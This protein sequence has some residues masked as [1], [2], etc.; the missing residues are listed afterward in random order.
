MIFHVPCSSALLL[1]H[2][3]S[4]SSLNLVAVKRGVLLYHWLGFSLLPCGSPVPLFSLPLGADRTQVFVSSCDSSVERSHF[5]ERGPA[6]H[7]WPISCCSPPSFPRSQ[8]VRC[9]F[10]TWD[11]MGPVD[12]GGASWVTGDLPCGQWGCVRFDLQWS[13]L[14]VP[15]AASCSSRWSPLD[16]QAPGDVGPPTVS[17]TQS[18]RCPHA[19]LPAS[20]SPPAAGSAVLQLSWCPPG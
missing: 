17:H 6:A 5:P 15:A 20:A 19:D 9:R 1:L 16:S 4:R 18:A 14:Q 13:F 10:S 12:P 11:F 2:V 8:L 7:L 3:S